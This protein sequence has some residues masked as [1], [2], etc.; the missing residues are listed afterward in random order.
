MNRI[1][2]AEDDASIA[3]LIRTVLVDAGYRCTWAPD[4]E[5][6]ADL[7]EKE[8]FDLALLD[9]MLPGVNGYDLLEYCKSLEVPVI[10]L[11]ALGGVEDRVRGLRSGAEDYLPKPFALPELLAR[12]ETVLRRCGKAERLL[13]LEPDIEIDPAARIVRKNG[14]PVALTAKE[15]DLLELLMRNP[16]RVY[17]RDNLLDLIWG[18]DYQGDARTVDV[19]IRRLREKVE[20]D[21]ASPELIITKWGVG[22]YF[23]E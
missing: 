23:A 18:Y 21:S 12:V 8:S 5:Q 9:I 22:Y 4:G 3:N 20:R 7:L 11:T 17:S 13:T 16:G 2:I 15:F 6:A 14:S 19:H 10:F 1:L